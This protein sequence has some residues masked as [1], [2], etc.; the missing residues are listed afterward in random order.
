VGREVALALARHSKEEV[1]KISGQNLPEKPTLLQ[2]RTSIP[3]FRGLQERRRLRTKETSRTRPKYL[4]T[5][6]CSLIEPIL[7]LK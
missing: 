6:K 1:Y 4:K 5:I 2:K 7:K 3:P